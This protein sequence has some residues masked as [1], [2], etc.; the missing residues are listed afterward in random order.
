M[1]H[2]L[3]LS[4][5]IAGAGSQRHGLERQEPADEI[6]EVLTRLVVDL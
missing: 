5:E 2:V 4:D 3:V 6:C 1:E